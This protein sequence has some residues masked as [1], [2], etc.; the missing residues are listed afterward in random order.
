MALK[1]S[2]RP[3][4]SPGEVR[5]AAS[6][7]A[8]PKEW[9][10][11]RNI[12]LIC[13]ECKE[14]PPN[15]V[16]EFTSGDYVCETCG[17][18]LQSHVIDTRSEWRTF[19]NDDQGNDDPSRVG[20]AANPLLNGEQLYST[21]GFGNNAASR[22]LNR[23]QQKAT[24]SKDD[25]TL[26]A[27]YQEIQALCDAM[28][29]TQQVANTA[30][31]L[32]KMT[33]QTKAFKGKSQASIIASCIFIACRQSNNPRTFKEIT[34][35]TK[36]PKKEIGR[37]FKLLE[38]F[39]QRHTADQA[40]VVSG[41]ATVTQEQYNITLSTKASELVDR[42]A[43]NLNLSTR[44]SLIAR[45]CAGALVDHGALAGRSPLSIAGAA[46]YIISHLM[47]DPKSPREISQ[48]AEVSDGT[49]RTAYKLVYPDR[50]NWVK[51]EWLDKG[52]DI[53]LL[54]QA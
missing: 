53:S 26:Q 45:D 42:Y 3:E 49:I 34:T 38:K 32:F 47:G 28:H 15:I 20:E 23:A 52:G 51:K 33:Q 5:E 25:R 29:F 43:S 13:P 8:E 10:L 1:S 41:G 17:V 36:V 7:P 39:F 18:V 48:V 30:K 22:D 44:I 35:L 37:T 4:L 50:E 16:E 14:F 54:P 9:T 11:D 19:S 31:H 12:H 40:V 27:A 21:I 2:A 46:L 6:V 24:N